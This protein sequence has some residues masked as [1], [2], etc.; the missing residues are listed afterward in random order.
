MFCWG[1]VARALR[2]SCYPMHDNGID[3]IIATR[4][5]HHIHLDLT[6]PEI[7]R[8]IQEPGGKQI[9]EVLRNSIVVYEELRT[10]SLVEDWASETKRCDQRASNN[11]DLVPYFV[12]SSD[13]IDEVEQLIPQL[14]TV[15]SSTIPIH[16]HFLK[17]AKAQL[18][19]FLS[20]DLDTLRK[21]KEEREDELRVIRLRT[22]IAQNYEKF[23]RTLKK[24][25]GNTCRHCG[26]D[27]LLEIDHVSPVSKGGGNAL[28]NLQLLCRNCN[29][30]K[31]AKVPE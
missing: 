28:E 26:T 23:K 24:R 30:K 11:D 17:W 9:L 12:I 6:D 27:K 8:A 3:Y 4:A 13:D 2:T 5:G 14:K 10:Y 7:I 22:E 1:D 18:E 20:L 25:D 29:A 16:P 15:L 21:E 19:C 31:R